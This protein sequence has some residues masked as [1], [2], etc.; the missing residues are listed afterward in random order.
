[1][2]RCLLAVILV[3]GL[4]GC[5]GAGEDRAGGHAT[6]TA[7]TLTLAYPAGDQNDV[8]GFVDAVSRLSHGSLRV[9]VRP[10]WRDGQLAFE[11]GEI[12]DVRAGK[13]DLGAA[14]SRAWDTVGIPS[15]RAL[16]APF[17]IDS[18]PLERR[19]VESRVA[20]GLLARLRPLGL[21][22][23]GILPS[24]MRRPLGSRK[25]LLRP[26]TSGVSRS[27]RSSRTSP[28]GRFASWARHP[29]ASPSTRNPTSAD[30]RET[31]SARAP[32]PELCS[33]QR[34]SSTRRMSTFGQGRP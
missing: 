7:R 32:S 22:G 14:A 16:H 4:V 12:A 6:N 8:L 27:R 3:A 20:A 33:T 31:S 26:A 13:A 30:S 23:L 34:V 5:G 11:T 21:V 15:F 19:V 9:V 17:L 18:Y 10:R 24:P 29:F 2:R 1:M 25:P 28:I